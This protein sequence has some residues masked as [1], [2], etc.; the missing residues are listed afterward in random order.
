MMR[1]LLPLAEDRISPLLDVAR[2]F[3]LVDLEGGR[4]QQRRPCRVDPVELLARVRRIRELQPQTLICGAVSR[5]LEAMLT[6]AGVRVILDTRGQ[7]D[8]VLAAFVADE[9]G[10]RSFAMPGCSGRGRRRRRRQR[11]RPRR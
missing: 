3:L 7:V 6:A 1:V 9:L 5:P 8:E 11:G 10:D 2:R 4:V